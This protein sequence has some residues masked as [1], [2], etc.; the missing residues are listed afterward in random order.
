MKKILVLII[1]LLLEFNSN[2]QIKLNNFYIG[3][4][5]KNKWDFYT[6]KQDALFLG[7]HPINLKTAWFNTEK[8][9]ELSYQFSIGYNYK[10][11]HRIELGWTYENY[12]GGFKLPY[13]MTTYTTIEHLHSVNIEN[14]ENYSIR[15]GYCLGNHKLKLIPSCAYTLLR[16]SSYING[17]FPFNQI[18]TTK[19]FDPNGKE[20]YVTFQ[21]SDI[22][23]TD[24]G[25]RPFGHTINGQLELEYNINKYLAINVGGG[26]T[27]GFNTMGYYNV[28]YS[29]TG[30]PKQQAINAVKG[31]HYYY[32][33][34]I[35][36]YPF[37]K[38][39]LIITKTP[40]D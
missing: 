30:Y 38:K 5:V 24:F 7:S 4:N 20:Y 21:A 3:F 9:Y 2:A 17:T 15:Y 31:T 27:Y 14:S 19:I 23:R 25:L 16:S 10:N 40:K 18:I 28:K 13:F 32:N 33:F 22:W 34:G 1:S 35:K 29:I 36:I 37:A 26:Y 11:K 12:F 6:K 8:Y 39:Q